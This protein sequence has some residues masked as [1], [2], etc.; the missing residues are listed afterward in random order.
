MSK[1]YTYSM[2]EGFM[3]DQSVPVKWRLYGYIN[4]FWIGGKAVFASNA[5]MAKEV[6]CSERQIQ[7]AIKELEDDGYLHRNGVSQNRQL[8]PVKIDKG[9][10]S[11]VVGGRRGASQG[12]DVGRPHISDSIS[13]SRYTASNE[14]GSIQIVDDT[15]RKVVKPAEHKKYE[16]L[17][18]WA[19]KRR[20]FKFVNRIKQYSVLKKAK[21]NGISPAKLKE[22]WQELESDNFFQEKGF[23]WGAVVTSFDKKA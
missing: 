18:Q 11:G 12:D 14:A 3:K 19:E 1:P 20:G 10:T 7:R 2:P 13:V 6:G 8:L 4:G 16:E 5:H 9:T 15:P 17:C 21:V 22:R 23:D